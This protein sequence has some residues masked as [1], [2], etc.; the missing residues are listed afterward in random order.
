[1][2]AQTAPAANPLAAEVERLS[3]EL[4]PQVVAWRRDFHK[5]PELGNRE[6]RTAKVIADELRKL[7]Y[8]VTTGV[9]TT[10]VVGVLKGG[11]PGPVVALRSDMDA[12]PVT[13]QGDLPFKSTAKAQWDGQEVGVMH[14]CGH[15][16]HMAILL[17]TATVLARMKDRLPGTVKVIFQPAE[18]GPPPGETGGAEQMVKESVLENPKVDAIFGLHVFPYPGRHHR[19]S[20]GSADGERRLAS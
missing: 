15:D 8:E 12:L 7:G 6:T 17:G 14:A 5:N 13:E 9:A 1:M 4:N 2:Q 10:G 20:V 11:L 16:N 19:L 18:E 3:V